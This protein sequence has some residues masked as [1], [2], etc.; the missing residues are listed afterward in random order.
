M[1]C[2]MTEDYDAIEEMDR[3]CFP[4]DDQYAEFVNC[5]WWIVYV[6]GHEAAYAGAKVW[7]P[8]NC[9]YF[10]RAGV[11]P[12]FRGR[13]IQRKMIDARLRWAK[14][15]G[16]EGVYTYTMPWNAQSS[17]NLI[18]SGFRVFIPGVFWGGEGALYWY[19]DL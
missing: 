16:C 2:E 7:E 14:K 18:E 8:D 10:C 6:D 3:I 9:A 1:R 13:G 15:E 5:E 11:L 12:E 17:N 4:L 19:R